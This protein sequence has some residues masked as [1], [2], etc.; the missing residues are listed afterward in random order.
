ML[1]VS[2]ATSALGARVS[3]RLIVSGGLALVAAGMVLFS[4]PGSARRG[5]AGFAGSHADQMVHFSDPE[6]CALFGSR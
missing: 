4:S 1:L 5:L 3:A 6:S 2:A